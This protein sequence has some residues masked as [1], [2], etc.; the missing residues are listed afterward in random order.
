MDGLGG[1]IGYGARPEEARLTL[2]IAFI[3]TSVAASLARIAE[4]NWAWWQWALVLV[5]A[6][7]LFGGAAAC[8]L[9]AS[10]RKLHRDGGL[11]RPVGFAALHVQPMLLALANTSVKWEAATA[12]WFVALLGV[13]LTLQFRSP[14]RR[15]F[16]TGYCGLS[17]ALVHPLI[18]APEL[19]WLAPVFII[20]LVG[21]HAAA[22]DL[23]DDARQ[24]R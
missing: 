22:G 20:K 13:A 9:P 1:E 7:D 19:A 11:L 18:S 16:A 5:L 8:A 23:A 15:G 4:V 6:F 2:A 14:L 21:A 17:I 3:G 12:L 10:A 24:Q